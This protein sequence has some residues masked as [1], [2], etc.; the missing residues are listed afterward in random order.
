M[1]GSIRAAGERLRIT[2][3]L[4]RVPD[5]VQVWS[6]SYDREPASMLGLQ[7]ELSTAIAEQIRLRLSADRLDALARRQTR[8]AEAYDL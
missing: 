7:R 2:S 8:D 5:Q 6:A 1:E 4:I 3:K